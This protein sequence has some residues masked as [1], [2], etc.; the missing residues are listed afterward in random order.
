MQ[1]TSLNDSGLDVTHARV[2]EAFQ[3]SVARSSKAP[4]HR[5]LLGR[6]AAS[7]NF[8]ARLGDRRCSLNCRQYDQRMVMR[9]YSNAWQ[10]SESEKCTWERPVPRVSPREWGRQKLFASDMGA[11]RFP[12]LILILLIERSRP[13]RVLEAG[14]ENGMN[15]IFLAWR[16]NHGCRVFGVGCGAA[17]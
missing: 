4:T 5:G 12:Q 14:Y 3:P 10:L 11:T 6:A 1:F 15:L 7:E 17:L 13:R 8:A 16:P 9:G 2:Y